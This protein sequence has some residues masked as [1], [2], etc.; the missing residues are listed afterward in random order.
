MFK[1]ALFIGKKNRKH[2]KAFKK[3]KQRVSSNYTDNAKVSYT[4]F[5]FT[6][7]KTVQA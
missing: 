3:H 1:S 6:D 7:A 4:C 2:F 5:M